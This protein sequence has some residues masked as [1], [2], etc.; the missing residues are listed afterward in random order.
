MAKKI[1]KYQGKTIEELQGLTLNEL[2]DIFPSDVRRRIK[3]GFS[4]EE[5]HV[6]ALLDAGK[7]NIKTHARTLLILPSMVG[8]TIACHRGNNFD[9]ILITDEMIG[10]RLGEFSLSRKRMT[11][12]NAGVGATRSSSTPS[13]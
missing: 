3:R 9:S 4:D 5:K 11:H 10:H 7:N 12:G 6:M 1:F 2:A 8:K 13:K